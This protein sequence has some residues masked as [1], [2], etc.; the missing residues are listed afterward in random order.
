LRN[1]C[2][3][4]GA[5]GKNAQRTSSG[6][7][8]DWVGVQKKTFTRW[9]N[10]YL[11]KRDTAVKEITVDFQDGTKLAALLEVISGGEKISKINPNPKIELQKME[12]LNKCLAFLKEHEIQ[13][14]NIGSQDVFKGNEKLI[15]GLLWCVFDT[16]L[17]RARTHTHTHT[18]DANTPG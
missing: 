18:H 3:G 10:S 15:L 9:A 8:E 6:H 12:N 5:N 17:A 14:V 7:N 13:L 2:T 1:A 4:E 16:R 11:A